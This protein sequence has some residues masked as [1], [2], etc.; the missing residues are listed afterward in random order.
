MILYKYNRIY[1]ITCIVILGRSNLYDTKKHGKPSLLAQ[2]RTILI[3]DFYRKYLKY[4]A[5]FEYF[6]AKYLP[7]CPIFLPYIP[8]FSVPRESFGGGRPVSLLLC[9]SE[10]RRLRMCFLVSGPFF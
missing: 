8:A 9:F 3:S 6:A 5:N 1:L 2:K 4:F 7:I 10:R